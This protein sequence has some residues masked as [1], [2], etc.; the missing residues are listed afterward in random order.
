MCTSLSSTLSD[1]SIF[2]PGGQAP[3]AGF[4]RSELIPGVNSGTDETVQGIKTFHWSLKTDSLKPLNYSHEYHVRL[5]LPVSLTPRF[6][7]DASLFQLLWHET[8]D[9]STSQWVFQTGTPFSESKDPGVADPRTL[10]LTG[11]QSE[12]PETQIWSTNFTED[13]WHNFALTVGWDSRSVILL[14]HS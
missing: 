12:T 9:Y 5:S 2:Q 11:R 7:L 6:S 4:R 8:N 10:R 3:Q 14:T 1:A 13:V